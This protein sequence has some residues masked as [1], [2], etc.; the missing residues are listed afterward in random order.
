MPAPALHQLEARA[1]RL[2][3]AG[4]FD[5][6]RDCWL[7][8]LALAPDSAEILLELSY[9][10]SLA[11]RHGAASEWCLRAAGKPPTRPET[12]V[13][14]VRR[15]RTFNAVP[16][17]RSLASALLE[18]PAP[19]PAVLLECAR[20]LSNLNDF[21]L[22]RQCARKTVALVPGN[23]SALLVRAQLQ[24]QAGQID[25]AAAAF[26]RI[27]A[28]Q[29]N[30]PIGW[31]ML[32][33]LRKQTPTSNHVA[34]LRQL[35]GR[36]GRPPADVA[37]LARALHKE[38]DDLGRHREAWD[39]LEL[40]CRA[41][42]ATSEHDPAGTRTLVDHLIA[43]PVHAAVPAAAP[44]GAVPI[45]IVGLHRS[46]TTLLE[47]LLAAHP[48]LRPLGELLD[49]TSA[50]R[51]ATDHYCRGVID[52]ELVARAARADFT[53]VGQ[54][55]LDG[56]RWRLD[57]CDWFTDKEPANHF[58]IGFI[59]R[60]LPQA[61]IL[62]MVR[63]PMETCFSNLRELFSGINPW[64]YD[65]LELAEHF[66]QYRRLM[67]HWREHWPGRI[68]DVSYAELIHDT[69]T[70]MRRVASFCGLDYLPAMS[71][72]RNSGR[73]VSTASSVQVREGVVRRETPKW[74]PYRE[75]LRP[76][77]D[78]L[79]DGGVDLQLPTITPG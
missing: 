43:T 38:L 47:Q 29:P 46:G 20:Q 39:A 74:L 7:D 50:M 45:F 79:K 67:A 19:A 68:L 58:N 52:D 36:P 26:E 13:S 51:Y 24:A 9:A 70:T 21:A 72:P 78:A 69:E 64:S 49:F 48:R 73:S 40:M 5:D 76:L 65:Q 6:A 55:Y 75:Q 1:H 31:W 77:I 66:I 54:R 41:R 42:R 14:L 30:I 16:T 12:Q 63:D 62:H 22:A 33:R 60:A 28:R 17:L 3:E 37:A 2:I 44:P 8:A 34:A 25:A 18:A 59:C 61:R 57:G 23:P 56:I 15:L 35:L 27:L 4:R 10:E 32:S 11:G 53:G 71:D